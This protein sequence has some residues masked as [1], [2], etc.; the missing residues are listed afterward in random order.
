MSEAASKVGSGR[1]HVAILANTLWMLAEYSLKIVSGIF[2]SIYVA[3]YLG[4]SD[5]GQLSYALAIVSIF[6]AISRL[7]MESIL[8][9]DMSS[10]PEMR[11][12]YQGTAFALMLCAS[13]V[14][15]ATLAGFVI[16]FE[17]DEGQKWLVG[18]IAI[19]MI[20]QPLMVVD[21]GFQANVA[22]KFSSIAKTLSLA[23]S[24][25]VKVYLV[26]SD[27]G[28]KG[29]AI[30]YAFDQFLVASLLLAMHLIKRQSGFFFKMKVKLIAPLLK[31][32]FPLTL[33]AVASILYTRVD[34]LMIKH[35]LDSGALGV[36]SS[37]VK[38]YEGWVIIPYV[39]SI[40]LLP[41]IV[42]LKLRSEQ[43]YRNKMT[44]LFSVMF[45]VGVLVALF[46]TMYGDLIIRLTFGSQYTGASS[47]LAIIMWA[48]AFTGIGSVS[49]RYLTVEG[50]E[51]NIAIRTVVA[52]LVN[53]SL[54][55]LLIP[56]YGIDGAAAATLITVIVANYFMN[57]VGS[58]VRG[59][60]KICN[61]AII[62]KFKN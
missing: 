28:L 61:D 2:V 33:S 9:R 52:L 10:F 51:K 50:L 39:I 1:R 21:Y 54:N 27:A 20:F 37:A 19:G 17:N 32:A 15:I 31:S 26:L 60:S 16:G 18:V 56:K 44:K 62:F 47:S 38:I 8:V 41:E 53:I 35:M 57:Y 45:W 13:M 22:A 43:E 59:L 24:S 23:I 36:Y 5:F 49:A 6:M 34:Q 46:S 12:E 58:E 14:S 4:P 55:L 30:A 40:S 7:G 3:R 25:A 42:G 11:K 48:A 29:L